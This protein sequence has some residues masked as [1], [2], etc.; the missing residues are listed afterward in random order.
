LIV[1]LHELLGHGTGKLYTIDAETGKM[2]F[3]E[4]ELNP[5][6]NKPAKETAYLSTETWS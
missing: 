5:Y 2:N 4:N 3:D 1:A 6:T